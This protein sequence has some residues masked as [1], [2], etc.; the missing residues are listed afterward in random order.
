MSEWAYIFVC[1][2]FVTLVAWIR[3]I[4]YRDEDDLVLNNASR[5]ADSTH[6]EQAEGTGR[7]GI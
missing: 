4:V 5:F 6:C 2:V 7:Q 3:L 1:I